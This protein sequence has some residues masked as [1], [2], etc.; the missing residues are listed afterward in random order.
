M[1][2]FPSTDSLHFYKLKDIKQNECPVV[3]QFPS[4]G[5]LHFYNGYIAGASYN[6]NGVNSLLR[7][8]C[9]STM[10]TSLVLAIT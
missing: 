9:I 1:Y 5:S 2:Q 10:V 6:I 8:A 7:V 3:C 4:T